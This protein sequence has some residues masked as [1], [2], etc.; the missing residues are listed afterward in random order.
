MIPS[1][2]LRPLPTPRGHLLPR[3]SGG[4]PSAP[5]RRRQASSAP[6]HREQADAYPLPSAPL[7]RGKQF[8]YIMLYDRTDPKRHQPD[9]S[10]Q[11]V[12]RQVW[13]GRT[14]TANGTLQDRVGP[15]H[16]RRIH[17]KPSEPSRPGMSAASA[18]DPCR[19]LPAHRH[20]RPR[21]PSSELAHPC[22]SDVVVL[23][24]FWFESSIL[25]QSLHVVLPLPGFAMLLL[26]PM[27]WDSL[28]SWDMEP[29]EDRTNSRLY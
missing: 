21:L 24:A 11:A 19:A 28:L 13:I 7:R 12:Q 3:D 4:R 20:R 27:A 29:D 25:R 8:R 18:D 1:L 16:P 22:G 14:D 23:A 5:A 2:V 10:S 17:F 15:A 9:R 6:S 26:A